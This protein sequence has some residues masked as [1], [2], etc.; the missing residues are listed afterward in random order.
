MISII[1]QITS[2]KIKTVC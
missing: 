2:M 1:L